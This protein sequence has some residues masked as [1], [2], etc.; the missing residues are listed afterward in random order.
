MANENRLSDFLGTLGSTLQD[1]N[2]P[3]T[4]SSFILQKQTQK[5]E[6]AQNQALQNIAQ[7][8]QL[9]EGISPELFISSQTSSPSLS[10]LKSKL[11]NRSSPLKER[12]LDLRGQKIALEQKKQNRLLRDQSTLEKLMKS[13]NSEDENQAKIISSEARTNNR[14]KIEELMEENKLAKT[15][16]LQPRTK[17]FA[18]VTIQDNNNEIKR[19]REVEK[20]RNKNF[21]SIKARVEDNARISDAIDK[22]ISKVSNST[23]G[24]GGALFSSIPLTEARDL[25]GIIDTIKAN[26]G[27]EQLQSMRDSSP[28][29]GALGQVSEREINFLQ[30]VLANLEQSQSPDQL[31]ENLIIAKDQIGKSLNRVKEAFA[32]DYGSSEKVNDIS[33][34]LDDKQV[35]Q[36]NEGSRVI[37]F[38][39]L[40]E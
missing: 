9:P 27:F 40:P 25:R 33:T 24:L 32:L 18:K 14:S 28:T 35:S 6:Q 17:E 5:K 36:E 10:V 12:E 4:L 15:A 11:D 3:G 19:L 1:V 37:D 7:S 39:K 30:S 23:A 34:S 20:S 13:L 26:L 31:R 22:A 21:I 16:L 8:G 29:G 38:S 2:R